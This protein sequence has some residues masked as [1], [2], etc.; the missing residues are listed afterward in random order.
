MFIDNKYKKWYYQII[1]RASDRNLLEYKEK[2]HIVPKSLGGTD[3]I[4]NIVNLTAREHLICH[5]LLTKMVTGNAYYKMVNALWAMSKLK[6]RYHQRSNISSRVYEKLKK[7]HSSVLSEMYK[8]DKNP[9]FGKTHSDKTKEK[10]KNRIVSITT[11]EIISSRQKDRF[12]N[13]S[14]TFFGKTHSNETKE[15]IRQS[16]LGKKDSDEVR[17]KKSLAGKNRLPATDETRKKLSLALKGRTGL[18]GERNG[19]Y[20]KKHSEAQREKKR[21]EKL[22]SPRLSCPYCHK[23]IDVMNFKRWHDDKCKERT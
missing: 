3:D 15:K 14:G 6:N 16:R 12:S 21:Q 7:E 9:F 11:K 20:G 2:H 5:I 17:E 8:G 10:M 1:N 23:I 19:F 13:I 22:N 4:T 18:K